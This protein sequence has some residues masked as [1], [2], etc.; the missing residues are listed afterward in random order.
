MSTCIF[1][2]ASKVV[3]SVFTLATSE[4]FQTGFVPFSKADIS[5]TPGTS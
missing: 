4:L 2:M 1:R 5:R 3:Y